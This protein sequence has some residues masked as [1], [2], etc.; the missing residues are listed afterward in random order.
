MKSE[1]RYKL[2]FFGEAAARRAVRILRSL[3]GRTELSGFG[4]L[5]DRPDGET[6]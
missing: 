3:S 5:F 4:Q 1:Y 2:I 6:T